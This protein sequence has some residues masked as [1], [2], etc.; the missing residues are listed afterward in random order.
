MPGVKAPPSDKTVL[1][2]RAQTVSFVAGHLVIV[3]TGARIEFPPG[4]T[5]IYV[6][7]EDPVGNVFPEVDMTPHGGEQGGV[8]RRHARFSLKDGELV[9]EDL[10][11][12]NFTF[13]NNERVMPGARQAVR[14]GD[15][16]RFG[17]IKTRYER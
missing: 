6:G 9:I 8:S 1:E 10:N 16:V 2:P 13:V 3:A 7:R 12:T 4:R 15:E 11:S 17:R 14:H 5:D